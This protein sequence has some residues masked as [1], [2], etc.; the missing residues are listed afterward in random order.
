MD[1]ITRTCSAA[2]ALAGV[3]TAGPALADVGTP[4][5]A[6]VKARAAGADG[7]AD[8]A[9]AGYARALAADPANAVVAARAYRE[10][11]A[12][13]D[14]R[15]ARASAAVLVAAGVAPADTALIAVADAV[16]ARR[17]DAADAAIARLATGTLDFLAPA[18][19]AWIAFGRGDADP[20]AGLVAEGGNPLS[21]RFN[22]ENRALLLI[23]GGRIDAGLALVR[24]LLVAS[25]GSVDFR[26]AAARLLAGQ[27]KA[28]ARALLAGTDRTLAGARD[29]LS[30]AKPDAAFGIARL[31]DR[32]AGDIADGE[33]RSLAIVLAR[34]ALEI[35][36]RDDRAR[37]ALANALSLDG[38]PARAIAVL[39]AVDRAGASADDA[40]SLRISVL[41]RA[42]RSGDAL[43]AARTL[44]AAPGAGATDAQRLGDLL[45]AARRFDEAAAAYATAIERASAAPDWT[46][47]LQRGGALDEAGR[48]DEART[49]LSRAVDLA[50]HEPVA[51]NYLGYAQIE[52]GEN[53][54]AARALLERAS[55]LDPED[56]NITDSLGWAYV[57]TGDIAKGV[58]LLE[59]AAR[60]APADTDIQEH[61]GDAYWSIGRRYEAR[62]AW[63]A[64]AVYA[65]ADDSARLTGKLATGPVR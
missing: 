47:F 33:A 6:Y 1:R 9:A 38:A 28:E 50:P 45:L 26:L 60:A 7:R 62:Y 27:G 24:S 21:R 59:R 43:A 44:A 32:L 36:P 63:R 64:A 41:N 13:G 14:M 54:A 48:W 17:W 58:P 12:V 34:A 11:L 39:D 35:D 25:A 55:R 42:G 3:L 22:D 37:L 4:L 31:Y 16:K 40:V 19:T 52:R 23:A 2:L 53:L 18:L 10:A 5:S 65:D 8:V 30:P 15:L 20:A 61:L 51:L 57:R 49:M 46:L 56:A 29:R